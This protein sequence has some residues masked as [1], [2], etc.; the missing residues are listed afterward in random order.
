[1]TNPFEREETR[2]WVKEMDE[3][4]ARLTEG[5][6]WIAA[7]LASKL[8]D[9]TAAHDPELLEGW[10]IATGKDSLRRW[11]SAHAAARR[12]QERKR[13]A[14]G[15]FAAYARDFESATDKN[16]QG[17]RLMG[18]FAVLHVVDPSGI[19]KRVSEMTGRDHRYVSTSYQTRGRRALME[20]AFHR[21]VAGHIGDKRTDQVY[22]VE[23]YE[24]LYRSIL[25][26]SP[27]PDYRVPEDESPEVNEEEA[28][29]WEDAPE[30]VSGA[31]EER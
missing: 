12:A 29:A 18:M 7:D 24:R 11:I 10:L 20:A 5:S 3:E 23:N 21:A 14:A 31:W 13:A 17:E 25:G 15:K 27:A 22:S 30:S 9:S 1:M 4:I 8:F 19:Q 2:D 16:T 6:G 28:P 26:E